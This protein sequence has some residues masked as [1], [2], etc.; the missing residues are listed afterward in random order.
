MTIT[1][2]LTQEQEAYVTAVAR[3]RGVGV[4]DLV[5]QMID[6]HLS[7]SGQS[8]SGDADQ[9]TQQS[10]SLSAD[11]EDQ[12]RLHALL[13][14]LLAHSDALA[15]QAGGLSEGASESPVAE[16]IR[17]KYRAQGLQV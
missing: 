12:R 5:A 4:R 8:M 3:Q 2:E 13:Q 17:A 11:D 7:L 16:A 14:D 1:I 6:A 9:D 10:T 15:R